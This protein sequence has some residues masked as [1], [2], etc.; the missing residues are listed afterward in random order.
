MFFVYH[1]ANLFRIAKRFGHSS[2]LSFAIVDIFRTNNHYGKLL[3]IL[4][5]LLDSLAYIVDANNHDQGDSYNSPDFVRY[6]AKYKIP[7]CAQLKTQGGGQRIAQ[8][9]H[10]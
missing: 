4:G 10:I 6:S 5:H 7:P 3:F 1:G 8:L 2:S 9:S